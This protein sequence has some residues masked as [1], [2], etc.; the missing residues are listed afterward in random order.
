MSSLPQAVRWSSKLQLFID[1]IYDEVSPD[2][3]IALYADDTK[4]WRRIS[5]YDDCL[6]LNRDINS[7]QNWAITNKM[8]FNTKKRKVLT[9]SLKRPNYYIYTTF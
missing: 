4:I 7:L 6:A 3:N 5:S 2:T 1:D 8:K 9:I